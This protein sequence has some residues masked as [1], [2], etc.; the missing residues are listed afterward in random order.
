[1]SISSDNQGFTRQIEGSSGGTVS[2]SYDSTGYLGPLRAETTVTQYYE[3]PTP[4]TEAKSPPEV[5]VRLIDGRT[6]FLAAYLLDKAGQT[7]V[8]W[9]KTPSRTHD[10]MCLKL[11][12]DF[13]N[14]AGAGDKSKNSVADAA[15]V[16]SDAPVIVDREHRAE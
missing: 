13:P 5:M 14:E 10:S 7:V 1:M 3:V 15:P 12:D 16:E 4:Q 8:L 6:L 2:Y 9:E 11:D